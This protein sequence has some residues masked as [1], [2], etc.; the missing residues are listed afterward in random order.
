MAEKAKNTDASYQNAD[1]MLICL[2]GD[3]LCRQEDNIIVGQGTYEQGGYIYASKSGII[4]IDESSE[5]CQ[6]VSVHKPGFHLTIPATGD[7]VTARV[8]V[9]TPKF[10][11]CA[12]FCVRNV[13]VES[14]YRGLLRK[15]DVRETD[16]DRVDIYKSFKPGDVILARVVNQMEQSF[17]LSTAEAELGVVVAYASDF[18]KYRIPMVPIG[19]SEM[20]CPQTTIKEPRK[21][22]KVLPE[23][24]IMPDK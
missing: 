15:E 2:P 11:K 24:S 1:D 14:S 21:V 22:A 13:L 5:K 7:V 9:T 16:K 6:I 10:A 4:N 20:Q 17:M 8:L 19:W 3:R 18:R 23:S 12:I